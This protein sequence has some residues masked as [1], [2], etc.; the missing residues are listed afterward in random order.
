MSS[1]GSFDEVR[2][3]SFEIY[4]YLHSIDLIHSGWLAVRHTFDFDELEKIDREKRGVGTGFSSLRGTPFSNWIGFALHP[5]V[6][7]VT[8]ELHLKGIETSAFGD[9]GQMMPLT[10]LIL[11]VGHWFYLNL[12]QL[13]KYME[14]HASVSDSKPMIAVDV[15]RF[16]KMGFEAS[17]VGQAN[18][19]LLT[20][21]R[22]D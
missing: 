5:V 17:E 14:G 4:W 15:S 18:Y 10:M 13:A 2:F 8:L 22:S 19:D 20:E 12:T 7:I 1:M 21:K 16:I 6:L 11:G 3:V 9:W